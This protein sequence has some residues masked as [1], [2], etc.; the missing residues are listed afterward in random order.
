[1]IPGI[2]RSVLFIAA[3]LMPLSSFAQKEATLWL[4]NADK[5]ALFQR[6][7]TALRFSRSSAKDPVIEVD[8]KQ[9]YQSVDGF[10]FALTGGSAQLMMRMDPEK[11]ASLLHELFDLDAKN[12]KSIGVSYLRVSVGSSDMNDRVFSYNDLPEGQTDPGMEKFSLAPDRADVIPVLKQILA[13]NPKIKILASPWSAPP[14]M[15]TN[16]NAKGGS[17]KPEYYDAYATYFVKYVQGMQAEGITID[18]LTVQNEPLNPKNTP[19][20]V[21]LAPEQGLFIKDHLGPAFEKAGIKTKVILYD[22]NCDRPDYPLEIL[23]DPEASKYIAGSG[24]HLY[25]GKIDALTEV[26]NAFPQKD[27]Y[28]TEQMVVNRPGTD[29]MSVGKPVARIVIGA[30]RNWSKNVLLWNLAADPKFE[31]HTNN[32]GCPVCQGAITIDG[33]EVTRNLAYYTVAHAS[34]F[35][36]PGSVRIGSNDRE[37]LPNVAF[38]TPQGGKVLIV[39]N[40]SQSAQRFAVRYHG[41]T[42]AASL[43]AGS[44][45]TYIW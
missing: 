23:K 20:M 6:Q 19:S 4:T 29:D 35:V 28:F 12:G 37:L 5:S 13:I 24:F 26:H 41:K 1:M 27:L 17:L 39:A 21:M 42:F 44:V 25:G 43:N 22:H 11:R 38:K 2:A 9:T 33:S 3:G 10:G 18:T 40:D 15:K 8:D 32:G 36:L 30:T 7:D 45:G 31:P 16:D 34:K 14:W